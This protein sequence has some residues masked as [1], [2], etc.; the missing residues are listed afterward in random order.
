[1]TTPDLHVT[2][3]ER[4]ADV[5]LNPPY[6]VAI[7]TAD[8]IELDLLSTDNLA[9]RVPTSSDPYVLTEL[10]TAPFS[11]GHLTALYMANA[12]GAAQLKIVLPCSVPGCA[13]QEIIVTVV[14][15]TP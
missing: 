14:V 3:R 7:R 5:L 6:K 4:Q 13:A 11:D 15:G 12:A 1:V 8:V 9:W 2:L 10:S